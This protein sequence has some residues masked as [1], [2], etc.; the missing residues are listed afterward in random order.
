[1]ALRLAG[2]DH[3]IEREQLG[4][5]LDVPL[6]EAIAVWSLGHLG[7]EHRVVLGERVIALDLEFGPAVPGD[8]VEEDGLLDRG[9]QGVADAAEHGVVGPDGQLVLP[10]LGQPPGVVGEVTLRV[11]DVDPEGLGNRGVQRPPASRDVIDRDERVRRRMIAVLVDEPDRV[12]HLHRMVGVEAREDLRDRAKVAVDELAQA[13]IV[14]NRA[15]AGAPGDEELE[16]WD[17]ERVLEVDAEEADAKGIVGGRAEAVLVGPTGRLAGAVLVRDPPD[18]V[19][20]V[21]VEV[22][23]QRKLMHRLR[24]FA[25]TGG[26]GSGQRAA[27]S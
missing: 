14:V 9:D 27:Q 25:I 17:A 19:D 10:A 16:A 15:R 18:F 24:S 6:R 21:W 26:R 13:T 22:G 2:N 20:T 3:G 12:E 23:R 5:Q 1:M 4:D 8:A 11:V 7:A